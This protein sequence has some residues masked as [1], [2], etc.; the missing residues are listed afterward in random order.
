MRNNI[1]YIIKNNFEDEHN[2]VKLVVK[3]G[4][5]Q[6]VIEI[7]PRE[8]KNVPC[9]GDGYIQAVSIKTDEVVDS[10]V[11]F[12]TNQGLGFRLTV[13]RE[14]K[15]WTLKNFSLETS[16]ASYGDDDPPQVPVKVGPGGQ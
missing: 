13:K 5:G 3:A 1:E 8:S 4:Q 12:E 14:G 2:P 11:G 15:T 16:L 10:Q 9:S 6:E 7:N